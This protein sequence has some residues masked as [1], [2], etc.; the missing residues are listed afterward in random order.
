MQH[1]APTP[2]HS[3]DDLDGGLPA[4]F[5]E[6]LA[7]PF[8][9][10]RTLGQHVFRHP[11]SV[12]THELSELT[13]LDRE[14]MEDMDDVRDN[15]SLA[16]VMRGQPEA[17]MWFVRLGHRLLSSPMGTQLMERLRPSGETARRAPELLEFLASRLRIL[18]ENYVAMLAA[19]DAEAKQYLELG[20]LQLDGLLARELHTLPPLPDPNAPAA[21]PEPPADEDAEDDGEAVCELSFQDAQLHMMRMV[22]ALPPV[23]ADTLETPFG[24][25]LGALPVFE[26]GLQKRLLQRLNDAEPDVKLPLSL[27]ELA[28]LFQCMQVC[29]ITMLTPDFD[30]LMATAADRADA[31]PPDPESVSQTRQLMAL[32]I[33]GFVE[34]VQKEFGDEP[35]IQQA[36]RNIDAL[37]ELL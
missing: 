11:E 25:A 14:F 23:M 19:D 2:N 6:Q 26:S 3:D 20:A 24:Q 1:D 27:P 12:F 28:L 32:M 29:G 5:Y 13:N 18:E 22:I 34:L 35:E 30:T 33:S 36:Q 9:L 31:G 16:D 8:S 4:G 15:A 37:T 17:F 7:T 10:A 21:E